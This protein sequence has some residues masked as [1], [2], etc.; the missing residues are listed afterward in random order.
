VSL[1]SRMKSVNFEIVNLG[2]GKHSRGG[3][4]TA[5]QISDIL[6]DRFELALE[7]EDHGLEYLDF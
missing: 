4:A 1:P 5:D 7:K 2:E 3:P 6:V